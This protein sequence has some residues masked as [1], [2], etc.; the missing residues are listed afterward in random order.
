MVEG[1]IG[2]AHLKIRTLNEVVA[3]YM[4]GELVT[5]RLNNFL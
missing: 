3:L 1:K 2:E 5:L 4:K